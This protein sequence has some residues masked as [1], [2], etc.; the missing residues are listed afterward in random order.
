M[1]LSI[2]S[3]NVGTPHQDWLID[4]GWWLDWIDISGNQF[5]LHVILCR[6]GSHTY[7]SFCFLP[8]STS[9]SS[10]N[11]FLLFCVGVV[12]FYFLSLCFIC[13]ESVSRNKKG[14]LGL[15]SNSLD[16]TWWNIR[17]MSYNLLANIGSEA[18]LDFMEAKQWVSWNKGK[19]WN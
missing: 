1:K 4:N 12:L 7:I 13:I 18:V 8:L 5:K 17:I 6:F 16:C 15:I 11:L 9:E 10:S 19:Y 14:I 2:T 3:S